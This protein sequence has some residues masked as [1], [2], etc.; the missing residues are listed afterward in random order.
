MNSI[1]QNY[2]DERT[3]FAIVQC[4]TRKPGLIVLTR[5]P[6][7]P[8]GTASAITRNELARFETW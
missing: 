5:A 8:K 2:S 7:F 3:L 6:R 4:V 1:F